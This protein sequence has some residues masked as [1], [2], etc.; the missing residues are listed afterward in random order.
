MTKIKRIC[1]FSGSSPGRR[2][3]YENAAKEL[4]NELLKHNIELVYGGGNVGLMGV[5][6]DTVIASGGKVIGVIP[7]FLQKQEVSHVALTELHIVQS[8]HERKAM[9]SE[10]SDAFIAMPGGI[11]TFEELLEVMTWQQL[12][13]QAKPCALLNTDNYFDHLIAL[14]EHAVAEEF[15]KSRHKKMLLVEKNSEHLVKL[16]F[17]YKY[18]HTDKWIQQGPGRNQA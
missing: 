2:S 8:M 6:A 17:D 11:G 15:L 14:L 3:S 7:E 13:V 12:G 5:I 18:Q 1:V 9:M 16:L 4:G 10:L